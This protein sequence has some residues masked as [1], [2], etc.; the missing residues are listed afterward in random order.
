VV[1]VGGYATILKDPIRAGEVA[2]KMRDNPRAS[3]AVKMMA[4]RYLLE[5]PR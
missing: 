1:F 5:N 2:Q 3:A 4:Q